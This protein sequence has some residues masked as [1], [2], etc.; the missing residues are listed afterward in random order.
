MKHVQFRIPTNNAV[1]IQK[2]LLRT[3]LVSKE[4]IRHS[5]MIELVKSHGSSRQRYHW[6]VIST[7]L[8]LLEQNVYISDT[9]FSMGWYHSPPN[10]SHTCNQTTGAIVVPQQNFCDRLGL[11]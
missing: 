10:M 8:D 1:Q 9:E 4:N 5:T 2:V 7:R 6:H 11:S 3:C